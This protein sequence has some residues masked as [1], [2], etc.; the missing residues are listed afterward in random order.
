MPLGLGLALPT[1]AI[2]E[3]ALDCSPE[4]GSDPSGSWRCC[5][6]CGHLYFQSAFAQTPSLQLGSVRKQ[7]GG[8]QGISLLRAA[9]PQSLAFS[10]RYP[11]GEES[12]RRGRHTCESCLQPQQVGVPPSASGQ[13][14][15]LS[16]V[17]VPLGSCEQMGLGHT[18][19]A[20]P[21]VQASPGS[22]GPLC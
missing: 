12:P 22:S 18:P 16:L 20:S 3:G 14:L 15:V 1:V 11:A 2:P 4:S 21:R 13:E 7:K 19:F 17:L 5:S 6:S 9:Q 8:L 10:R